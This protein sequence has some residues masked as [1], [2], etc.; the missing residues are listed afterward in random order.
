MNDNIFL[1][2][3]FLYLFI[4]SFVHLF[5]CSFIHSF[6]EII[7]ATQE[8]K[9]MVSVDD[10]EK[11]KEVDNVREDDNV[12]HDP[13]EAY[14]RL[15][16]MSPAYD[17]SN[18][19]P[20]IKGVDTNSDTDFFSELLDFMFDELNEDFEPLNALWCYDL[21]MGPGDTFH[22]PVLFKTGKTR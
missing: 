8:I 18:K 13:Q 2:E 1:R 10:E 16:A 3:S 21:N 12:V 7:H 19:L 22:N 6:K 14:D 4:C 9:N 20:D 17:L 15:F 11:K 5:I